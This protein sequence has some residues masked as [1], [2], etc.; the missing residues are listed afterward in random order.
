MATENLHLKKSLEDGGNADV[1]RAF[2]MRWYILAVYVYYSTISCFQWVEYSIIT[3]IVMRYYNVSSSAVD[4]T[5]VMFMIV[6]PIFVFPSSFL[7]DKLG[8]RFAALIGCFLTAIG[9]AIKLFSIDQG[10]F[11]VVLVGQAIVSLSQVF[12]LSLPPKL[13]VTWFRPDEVSK[14]CS[15]GV[16][17]MQ[18]GSALGFLLPPMLVKDQPDLAAIGSDLKILCWSLSIAIVPACI[19]VVVYFPHMPRLPPSAAQAEERKK[20]QIVTMGT[21]IQ[22]LKDLMKNKGFLVHMLGYGISFGIF[23]AFGTLLNQFVLSYFPGA[24]EDAGRMGLVMIMFGMFGGF[25]AGIVLDKTHKYKETNL[26]IYIGTA[27]CFIALLLCL[28]I[29]AKISVYFTI[30]IFGFF[31]NAYIPAG[32]EF[33][34][35]LTYPANESTTT[36]LMTA[37]SQT[38][39]VTFTLVLSHLNLSWGTL[40]AILIQIV[41]L[42]IGSV[43]TMLVPN[44]LRRQEAFNRGRPVEFTELPQEDPALTKHENS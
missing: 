25:M 36:G 9:A 37:V 43:L 10:A 24:T 21:F 7:I 3:N 13:A 22:S 34:S 32:I 18:L 16:F 38:L 28:Q 5:G 35:E 31:L 4:W 39:G 12:I 42:F 30:G 41:L 8:L 27:L 6:W 2:S 20:I 19:A 1:I 26:F 15:I 17:G 14:V 44:N 40:W 23:S 33:A 29:K 11:N